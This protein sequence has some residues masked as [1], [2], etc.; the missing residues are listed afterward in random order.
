MSFV[1]MCIVA[2][3]ASKNRSK[4]Q[5]YLMNVTLMTYLCIIKTENCTLWLSVF[6]YKFFSSFLLFLQCK[7]KPNMTKKNNIHNIWIVE[8]TCADVIFGNEFFALQHSFGLCVNWNEQ[9]FFRLLSILYKLKEHR[10]SLDRLLPYPQS[11][12]KFVWI[13]FQG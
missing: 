6:E 7:C 9:F 5:K 1:V 13:I 4:N 12:S 11:K 8:W 2:L 3:T 10:I